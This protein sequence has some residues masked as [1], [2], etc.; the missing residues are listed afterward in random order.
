MY[1]IVLDTNCGDRPTLKATKPKGHIMFTIIT[2]LIIGLATYTYTK[3]ETISPKL[4][5]RE[6]ATIAG[7]AIGATPEV[8]RTTTKM[9]KAA[10][11][12]TELELRQAGQDGPVGFRTGTVIGKKTTRDLFSSINSSS[13]ELLKESLA[14]LAKFNSTK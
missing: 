14:E 1:S 13:D 6:A 12:K 2:L 10:N 9:V 11:A 5:V 8:V 7:L 4:L 3:W